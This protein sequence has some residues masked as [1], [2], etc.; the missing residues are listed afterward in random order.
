MPVGT[1]INFQD[2]AMSGSL[3]AFLGAYS[4]G[5]GIFTGSGGALTT[6]AKTGDLAPTG[7]FTNLDRP[8]LSG[9]SAAFLGTYNGS[10]NKGI[11]TGGGG[12][13]TTIAKTG[14]PAPAG[15]F[16]N[17][18]WPAISGST[19]AFRGYYPGG[20]GIFNGS[21]GALTTIAKT[22]DAAPIGTF[23]D[24]LNAQNGV[25][26]SGS[27]TVFQ[28]D[29]NGGAGMGIFT[30]NGGTPMPVIL[31]GSSL[32]GSTVSNVD[33][34]SFDADAGRIAFRYILSDGRRGIAMATAPEPSSAVLAALGALGIA[35]FAWRRRTAHRG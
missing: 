28:A 26:L 4:A 2:P 12:A 9:S 29:Y 10:A 7:T 19:A 20:S 35:M 14:D 15:T 5:S 31:R 21:G 32:F 23:S 16:T 33:M 24:F 30:G 11:F 3:A 13:L 25:S 1:F 22:G 8:A 34:G 18:D 17:F 27:T 6:I